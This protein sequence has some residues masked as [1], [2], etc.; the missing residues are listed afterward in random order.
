M[1]PGNIFVD[2]SDPEKP[3]YCAID[4]GI[5][6]SLTP[7]D[8]HYLAEN[9][10]AFFNRDY[11]RVAELHVESG[12]VPADTRVTDFEAA[13]RKVSEPIFGRPI[14]DISFG[15]FLFSLFQ[16]A[17]R[18]N[19]EVQPQ[20]VLLEKTFFNVEGLGR[21]LYPDLDLWTTAK[22]V[23]E[24]WMKQQIG[25]KAML[26]RMRTNAHDYAQIMPKFPLMAY[27]LLDRALQSPEF[28]PAPKSQRKRAIRGFGTIAGAILLIG[29]LSLWMVGNPHGFWQ[30]AALFFTA[31]T[32]I[33]L[34][35]S[36]R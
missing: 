25:P 33:H 28:L 12:W 18:F 2:I 4:F 14:K 7:E 16:T 29:A 10:L 27:R 17:R 5:M 6:G 31:V 34:L 19:M 15:A 8:Q 23:L 11:R 22:P 32:G 36:K 20:L 26:K 35:R 24:D 3:R 1:H 9:F 21:R 13:I 30:G